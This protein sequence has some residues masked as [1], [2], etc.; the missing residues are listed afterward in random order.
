MTYPPYGR[1]GQPGPYGSP[2]APFPHGGIRHDPWGQPPG[3]FQQFPGPPGPPPKKKTGL[4]VAIVA[5]AV[6]LAGGGVTALL[7]LTGSSSGSLSGSLSGRLSGT[8]ADSRTGDPDSLARAAIDAFNARNVARYAT[9]LCEPPPQS[10]IDRTQKEWTAAVQLHAS[11]AGSPK[12][13]GTSA[14]VPVTVQLD[15]Q[16]ETNDVAMRQRGA[17]W[18]IVQ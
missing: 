16:T 17:T 7:L 9:L 14:S 6:V 10:E 2:P 18:C 13:T 4:V 3:T 8:A 12:I 5:A 11:K 15:G 1:Q